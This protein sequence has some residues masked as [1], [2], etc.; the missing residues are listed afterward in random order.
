LKK[1]EVQ[2]IVNNQLSKSEV[3]NS[4]S[5]IALFNN[6]TFDYS[7][8]SKLAYIKVGKIAIIDNQIKSLF[9]LNVRKN[10]NSFVIDYDLYEEFLRE[11][12]K[13]EYLNNALNKVCKEQ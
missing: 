1:E 3:L 12:I 2:E 5:L 10:I 6:N 9:K 8:Y 13:D 4:D 11:I 7:V